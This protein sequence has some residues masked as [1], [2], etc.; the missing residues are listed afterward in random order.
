MATLDRNGIVMTV[1]AATGMPCQRCLEP[2]H[3]LALR[4]YRRVV[5]MIILDR[6]TVSAGYFCA[7]C[8]RRAFAENM[9]S[10]LVLGWWGLLAL[11]FR[12]PFAIA[13]N[14]WALAA[15]P[16][17]A[18]TLGALDAAELQEEAGS[19]GLADAYMSMPTWFEDIEEG[20]IELIL[21]D[22]DYYAVLGVPSTA[23]R[24]EIRSAHRRQ[25]KHHHPDTG[26]DPEAMVVVNTAWQVLGNDRLRHAYDHQ[27]EL[28]AFLGA[29]PDEPD[30]AG[31]ASH[32][33]L[34]CR[35]SFDTYEEF[36]THVDEAHPRADYVDLHVPL[37]DGRPAAAQPD[38]E[39]AT[40]PRV[41][42][43][44]WRCK[45]CGEVFVDYDQALDHAD[46]AHPDRVAVDIRSAVEAV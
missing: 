21:S 41:A 11:L 22:I 9:L 5:G 17:N 24:D 7:A 40:E 46:A 43:T 4:A 13:S 39:T 37:V 44:G 16:L 19:Q 12:N 31:S 28:L 32:G 35:L 34:A 36:A 2:G 23:S 42:S 1:P 45:A 6:V 20:E 10:T 38:S 8:R 26:G 15:G 33:C 30:D 25:A 14:I 27:E 18:D 3:D 29:V